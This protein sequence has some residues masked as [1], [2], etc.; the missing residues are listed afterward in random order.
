[1]VGQ[2]EETV[3]CNH[4]QDV[5]GFTENIKAISVSVRHNLILSMGCSQTVL[6]SFNTRLLK[7]SV[8]KMI[9][10]SIL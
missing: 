7:I 2:G 5:G 4:R 3:K 10:G 6:L 8:E 1:M 9:I